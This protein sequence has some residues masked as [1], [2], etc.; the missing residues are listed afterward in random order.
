MKTL[1]KYLGVTALA[2]TLF[3]G[4]SV[5][6]NASDFGGLY[7]GVAFGYEDIDFKLNSANIKDSVAKG[8]GYYGLTAGY[9]MQLVDLV[10]VG[11]EANIGFQ[12]S[13]NP[14]EI[15]DGNVVNNFT[16]EIKGPVAFNAL[17]GFL[18]TD[19]TL[20]FATL[21]YSRAKTLLLDSNDQ[22]ITTAA[23]KNGGYEMGLGIEHKVFGGLGVRL[24]ASYFN[25]GG[26]DPLEVSSIPKLDTSGMRVLLGA[27]INF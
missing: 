19:D 23:S 11:L 17:A 7:A 1:K 22:K 25:A 14:L 8:Q 26:H 27:V 2:T 18:L 16:Q 3:A 6:A 21:G 13:K 12:S 20:L 5:T 15:S 4:G 24:T 9:R 10:I